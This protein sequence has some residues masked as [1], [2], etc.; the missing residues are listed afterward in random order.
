[1]QRA[2][3]LVKM[4]QQQQKSWPRSTSAQY[5]TD[6]MLAPF[7]SNTA[8]LPTSQVELTLR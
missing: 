3:Q 2:Q 8:V 7:V 6:E 1:M 5:I 4:Q